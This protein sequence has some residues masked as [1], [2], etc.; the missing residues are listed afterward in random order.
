MTSFLNTQSGLNKERW[1]HR[2]LK[3]HASVQ[4]A[5]ERYK[6]EL[7]AA[8]TLSFALT[9]GLGQLF[10]LSLGLLSQNSVVVLGWAFA[11]VALA[12]Y[13]ISRTPRYEQAGILLIIGFSLLSYLS[14]FF[15][16]T[17]PALTLMLT[18]TLSFLLANLA[19][20][21][22]MT[23]L[24]GINALVEVIFI[25]L[26]LPQLQGQESLNTSMGIVTIGLFVLLFAWYRDNLER[27]RLEEI[28]RAQVEL[29]ERNRALQHAQQEVNARLGELRLAASVS[30]AVSQA[31]ALDD[32]LADAVETIREQFG[33][34]YAQVYLLNPAR[35]HLVLQSGTGEVGRQLKARSHRLPLDGASLNARAVNEQQTILV[36]DTATSPTF[37]PNPLL[38]QTRSEVAIPLKVGETV[39]GTLDLQS[40]QAN[41]FRTENL[42]A[43]ETLA[44]Q[45]A[46]AIQNARLLEETQQARAEAE[47]AARRLVRRNWQD[48]L[49]ALHK[50]ENLAF[51][52]VE[53]QIQ[54]LQESLPVSDEALTAPLELAGQPLGQLSV[55]LPPE[56]R[57]PQMAELLQSVARQ[58]TQHIES[59]RLLESAERYRAQ[60][61]EASRRL[62]HE[63]WQEYFRTK[64]GGALSYLYDLQ[65]VK[66]IQ[67]ETELTEKAAL[68][69]PVRV[70]EQNIGTLAVFDADA[71][72]P[73]TR[74]LVNA[75]AERLSEHIES[76]R[77][78]EET[79]RGQLELDKRARQLAAVSEISTISSRE[80]DIN[81]LLESVVHLTQR[82]FGLYHAHVFTYDEQA[83]NLA[84][85]ACGWKEGDEHEGT[86][87]TTT[88]PLEQEQSLVARA[89]R[90]RQ[91]VVV[92]D[93]RADPGWLPN[94]LLP[95]TKSEL[96]VP[97][98]VGE[99]LL[100]VLDVQS[101]ELN[102]FSEED[103][104]I[105]MTLAAQVAT[106]LQNAR[107]YQRA[108]K[109]AEREALLNTINQKI[110]SATSVEAV[111]QIAARELGRALGAPRAIAQLSLKDKHESGQ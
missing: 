75:V 69:V 18:L 14:A 110:Q 5:D 52:F 15:D 59:L 96:A 8:I 25:R 71:A 68:T 106:A 49:D 90:T 56:S 19:G 80:S 89:A 54:P 46:I 105:Q 77:L 58:V 76:L 108:Q 24:I 60:A 9:I 2:F 32:L 20:L 85:V 3:A 74:E 98:L 11:A 39:I 13:F 30:A 43:F 73:E 83:K 7:I 48:Y 93:V 1:W 12:S 72:D 64:E 35:T 111:L 41:A 38:P 63:G 61:E 27:L 31:R 23:I 16:A 65:E 36:Q 107:N 57:T 33:L 53:N 51:A 88:I 62:T 45:L 40:A 17:T 4:S 99:E 102:H 92:N 22:W 70:Q 95:D 34:Y 10:G 29:E 26:F 103:I 37:K 87:E 101:D 78:L 82:K 109:Q 44:G 55:E 28:R 79:Q 81:R 47:R 104:A 97:L 21:K 42:P 67:S 91:P 6:A 100:G 50:P 86:H 84:I 66:P 94:P